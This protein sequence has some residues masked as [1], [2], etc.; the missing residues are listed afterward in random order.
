[1]ANMCVV[2]C[3]ATPD[4]RYTYV[5]ATK[6]LKRRLRQHN[7]EIKGGAKYTRR[8]KSWRVLFH[9]KGFRE[10]REALSFEWHL[11]HVTKYR[12][13]TSPVAR[14]WRNVRTLLKRPRWS[15]VQLA[16]KK[17]ETPKKQTCTMGAV[18]S[19]VT[20]YTASCGAPSLHIESDDEDARSVASALY[21][22]EEEEEKKSDFR[23]IPL[24]VP[25][26]APSTNDPADS[27]P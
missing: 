19:S 15:H 22:G 13:G 4:D 7:G 27:S 16:D 8:S 6:N 26:A 23:S 11:K 25:R 10:W 2:Y 3:L 24:E 12:R 5:G 21:V 1:M 14:R 9:T 17:I 18:A 20:D